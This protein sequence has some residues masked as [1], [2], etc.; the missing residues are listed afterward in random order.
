MVG[1][2]STIDMLF[3]VIYTA[4]TDRDITNI[5]FFRLEY[6]LYIFLLVPKNV[7]GG[8]LF[9]GSLLTHTTRVPT[10]RF[11]DVS[12]RFGSVRCSNTTENQNRTTSGQFDGTLTSKERAPPELTTSCLA[13]NR[14]TT[15]TNNN[16]VRTDCV[17]FA[18]SL[19]DEIFHLNPTPLSRHTNGSSLHDNLA[20]NL[21]YLS[22]TP[23][24]TFIVIIRQTISTAHRLQKR[25][26]DLG[27]G[28]SPTMQP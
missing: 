17:Y 9:H 12:P 25:V 21:G 7:R 8:S 24:L 11:D 14:N 26:S 3:P 13:L 15:T 22:D 5:A 18:A 28:K 4:L 2:Y 1:K 16:N 23:W 10:V 27:Q 19:L 6:L 20:D